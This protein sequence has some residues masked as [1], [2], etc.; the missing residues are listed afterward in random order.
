MTRGS[1]TEPAFL[2]KE[3]RRELAEQFREEQKARDHVFRD[4]RPWPDLTGKAVILAGEGLA[5]GYTMLTAAW[6]TK[7]R[8]PEKIV[9]PFLLPHCTSLRW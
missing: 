9:A 4:Y 5:L 2:R 6:M 1:V 3:R 8:D 7:R